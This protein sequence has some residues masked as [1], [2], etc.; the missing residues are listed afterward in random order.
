[1]FVMDNQGA[2]YEV[3]EGL[4]TR[5][6]QLMKAPEF[7]SLISHVDL[8]QVVFLRMSGKKADWHG[9]CTYIGKAPQTIIAKYV[10]YKLQ[11]FGVLDLSQLR[12]VDEDLFDIRYFITINDD[13]ICMTADSSKVED[14]VIV[15]ELMHIKAT[16]DG[17]VK[18]DV[19]DFS[20]IQKMFG[21]FWTQGMFPEAV[22][23]DGVVTSSFPNIPQPISAPSDSFSSEESD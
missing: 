17:V 15:H 2:K 8:D 21:P 20:D 9:K 18:H 7:E 14:V 19:E 5:A 11:E 22:D 23:A 13:T 16:A 10:V 1:M 6:Q 12:N 3:D 4:R